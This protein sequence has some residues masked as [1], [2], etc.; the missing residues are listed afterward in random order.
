MERKWYR[1]DTAAL[2]FPATARRDWCNVFRVSASLKEPIDVEILQRSVDEMRQRFPSY[3]V[4]LRKGFFWYYLEDSDLEPEVTE[5]HLPACSP[6]YYP[7]R[8]NL[9]YRVSYYSRRINLEMFHVLADGTGGFVF[10]KRLVSRY[11]ELSHD[12]E[13]DRYEGETSS[14]QEKGGDAIM[15]IEID[16]QPPEDLVDE[17]RKIDHVTNA[18][19]I[20]RI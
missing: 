1:L 3:F 17:I 6:I 14:V 10:L 8:V 11:L 13:S 4:T 5:D 2:I 18:I 12:I 15:T 9:L 19:L 7:G 20:R 16:N